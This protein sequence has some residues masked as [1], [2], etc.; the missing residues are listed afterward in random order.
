MGCSD[1]EDRA[2]VAFDRYQS[3]NVRGDLPEA[4]RAL[5]SLVVI[6]DTNPEYWAELG[7]VSLQT[8]DVGE[9]YEG[10]LRAHELDRDNVS[11]LTLLTQLTL[12]SGNFTRAEQLARDLELLDPA[13]ATIPLTRG[14]SALR[15]GDLVEAQ[16]QADLL[17][18]KAPLDPT[19]TVLQ[20]RI[21]LARGQGEDAIRVLNGSLSQQET[22]QLILQ[23]LSAIHVYREEWPQ[24][25]ESAA[26]LLV[27]RP[28]DLSVRG[29]LVEAL[30]RAGR[31]PAAR[32]ATAAG[33]RTA[34]PE[35]IGELLEPWMATGRTRD[36]TDLVLATAKA[37]PGDARTELARFLALAG[38]ARAVAELTQPDAALPPTAANLAANALYGGAIASLG[39]RRAGLDRLDSVLA[40]DPQ[41]VDALRGRAQLRLAQAQHD[42]AIEDGRKLV[43]A[44]RTDASARLL[45]SRLF[46]ANNDLDNARRTLWDAFHDIP[47]DRMI[48]EALWQLLARTDG[49]QAAQRLTKEFRDQKDDEMSRSFV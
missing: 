7:R 6:D 30:L 46:L 21:H 45:L 27:W 3:A 15:R 42:L 32:E 1:R 36:V 29:S 9:A 38:Q 19:G 17:R 39:D 2:R 25:A 20:A 43:A 23:A 31:L 47:G 5:Q 44:D 11:Y 49:P 4:K 8:G 37:R 10:Y 35:Q 34:S 22:D 16:N 14:Y 28:Q 33:L 48:F 41:Q 13:N 24:A 18:E 40:V 26:R 12:R